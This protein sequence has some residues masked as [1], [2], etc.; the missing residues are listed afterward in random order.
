MV[1]PH[2]GELLQSRQVR[3][4]GAWGRQRHV[5][6]PVWYSH[7]SGSSSRADRSGRGE[8]G[9]DSGTSGGRGGTPTCRGAPPEPTGPAEGS[10]GQTAA[11]QG[12]GVVLPH[13]GELLQS[14]QVRQRGAWGR[15]R[16]VRGPVWY[17]HMSGSSSRADRSG[18]GEP[19]V[20]SGTSGDRCGTPTCRGAPPEPTGPAEGSLGQT[21][22]RQGAGVVLPHVGELLQSR[23]VR[24]RGAW[25]RQRHVRGPVWY[26]HMSGSSSR[27]DRSGRGEPGVGSGTSGDRCG[28]PTCRGAPPEPTGPAEGS[29]GQ[30]AARQGTGV[31]L[32]Y[33]GELLQSR[34]V[35]QRGAWGTEGQGAGEQGRTETNRTGT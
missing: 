20:G 24:Q 4:R 7:M 18:R 31:V 14:R 15:Q 23:Q 8:P 34:Q 2:V 35:R 5:R 19:G 27:A 32:P 16:H 11:R 22:A 26:S 28:T 6:G 30:T 33:V 17:S 10:L 13:V 9:V 12:A 3:Q 25:G 29:L 21:A 1:L